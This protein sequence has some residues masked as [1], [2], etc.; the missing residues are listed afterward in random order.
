MIRDVASGKLALAYNVLGS[1]AESQMATTQ[2]FQIVELTDFVNVMLRTALIPV[3]ADNVEGARDMVDFLS[4]LNT[5]PDLVLATGSRRLIPRRC[6][7]T[8]RSGP[9]DLAPVCWFFWTR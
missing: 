8:L 5:R 6:R 9:F 4:V 1:Y 2:G 3:N 7:K